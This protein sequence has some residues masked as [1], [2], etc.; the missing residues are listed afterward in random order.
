MTRPLLVMD[1]HFRKLEELFSPQTHAA[2]SRK[3]RIHGGLNWPM[4][5]D[6]RAE[7]L[8]EADF[9][10]AARPDLNAAEIAA[11]PRLR[12]IIE[13]SGAFH[14]ELD[15]DSCFARGIDVLSCAPGF[16][17]AVAEMG[18]AMILAAGRGLVAEHEA[19]RQG[20]E[21]WLDDGEDR[22][23]TLF[24]A[25]VG[26]VGYGQIARELAGLMAP[27]QP[28]LSA[29]DPWLTDWP[30]DVAAQDLDTLFSSNRIVVVTAV[31][32]AENRHM[33]DAAL[34]DRLPPG[35]TLVLLSRAHVADV[36]AAAE[37]ARKGRITFATDVFPTEP[38]DR[39]DPLRRAP[40][41]IL[42]PHRAA[43]VPGGRQPI[44]DM[45]LHDVTAL[46]EGRDDRHLLR[47]D[48]A[49]VGSLI[50]AQAAIAADG[51]LSNT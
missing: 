27:F 10:V 11:A 15:Y 41:V 50:A 24:G 6:A 33:V 26:F 44:G 19:F 7:A 31:P 45:I 46:L 28:R 37:A 5:R 14:G 13:V 2:L 21:R 48:P 12:A 42:S 4:D 32:T 22:D 1:Q 29:Y 30:E 23:A 8:A 20:A 39:E 35:A 36:A 40:G 47:A 38:L 3:V 9:L 25:S 49:R 16:R 17:F 34:I 43:A 51:R 18:L